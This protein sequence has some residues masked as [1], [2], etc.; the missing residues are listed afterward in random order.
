MENLKQKRIELGMTQSQIAK[1]VGVSLLAYQMWERGLSQPND[2]NKH[3]LEKVL[4]Q[5][6]TN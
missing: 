1:A 2:L 6:K 4:N 3:K 5:E